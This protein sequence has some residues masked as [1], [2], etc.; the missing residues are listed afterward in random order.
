MSNLTVIFFFCLI[1]R[2]NSEFCGIWGCYYDGYE[3]VYI[4]G[5]SDLFLGNTYYTKQNAPNFN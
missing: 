4:L 3:E 5:Y 2:I 1:Y